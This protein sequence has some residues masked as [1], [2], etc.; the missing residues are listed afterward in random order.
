MALVGHSQHLKL[1]LVLVLV[2]QISYHAITGLPLKSVDRDELAEEVQASPQRLESVF[3]ELSVALEQQN[4]D[5]DEGELTDTEKQGD[6]EGVSEQVGNHDTVEKERVPLGNTT[7][8]KDD[9]NMKSHKKKL[10]K[11]TTLKQMR[12]EQRRRKKEKYLLRHELHLFQKPLD[13]L[14]GVES[15][16]TNTA[17]FQSYVKDVGQPVRDT[18]NKQPVS[19]IGQNNIVDSSL[20]GQDQ[21]TAGEKYLVREQEME[22]VMQEMLFEI[23][24]SMISRVTKRGINDRKVVFEILNHLHPIFDLACNKKGNGQARKWKSGAS[25]SKNEVVGIPH[26]HIISLPKVPVHTTPLNLPYTASS[27]DIPTALPHINVTHGVV[28]MQL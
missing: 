12:E 8:T 4:E 20:F 3:N 13:R 10:P 19:A 24:Q 11:N 28:R 23:F 26:T 2:S 5:K 27:E 15:D 7:H 6:D 25:D 1:A 9:G 18:N 17:G 21:A 16:N 22:A 14:K